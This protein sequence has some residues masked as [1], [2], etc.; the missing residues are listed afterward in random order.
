MSADERGSSRLSHRPAPQNPT[1]AAK[2]INKMNMQSRVSFAPFI[3]RFLLTRLDSAAFTVAQSASSLWHIAVLGHRFA[4]VD[5][6][7]TEKPS[8]PARS[9][10]FFG[11]LC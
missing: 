10:C 1:N 4:L 6:G 3:S 9:Y 5:I 11:I 7:L 2:K 8:K